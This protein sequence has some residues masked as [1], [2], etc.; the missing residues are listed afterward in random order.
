[1]TQV[2]T[3]RAEWGARIRAAREARGLTVAKLA[4]RADVDQGNLSRIERGV[5]GVSDDMRMRIS[6]ALETE[7][8]DLF[9]YPSVAEIR[10]DLAQQA[11]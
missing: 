7:V 9:C 8:A 5:Q 3:L 10:A 2:A 1:M 6:A 11:A 4:R